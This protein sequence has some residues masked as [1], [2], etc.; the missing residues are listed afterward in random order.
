MANKVAWKKHTVNIN[1]SSA[2]IQRTRCPHCLQYPIEYYWYNNGNLYKDVRMSQSMF[3]WIK[4]LTKRFNSS[5]Y[6][7]YQPRNF[8]NIE[9]F[10]FYWMDMS[11]RPILHH[12][13]GVYSVENLIEFLTC[14]CGKSIWAFNQKSTQ[15]RMEIKNRKGRYNYPKKFES[16]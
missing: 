12:K 16:W 7:K 6:K 2:F 5:W 9:N 10:S 4:K 13:I 11:Y 3:M 14:P 15:S 1:L 8:N